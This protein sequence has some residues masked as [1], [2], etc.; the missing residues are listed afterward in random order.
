MDAT[1]LNDKKNI[2]TNL[3]ISMKEQIMPLCDLYNIQER[4]YN[5]KCSS[6]YSV[7]QENTS[8]KYILHV[9]K[10]NVTQSKNEFD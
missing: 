6:Q 3:L 4:I 5:F 9:N 2:A 1:T 7:A 10:K 8:I